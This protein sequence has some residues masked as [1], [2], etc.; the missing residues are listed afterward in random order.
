MYIILAY[1]IYSL[2]VDVDAFCSNSTNAAAI[3]E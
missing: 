1:K 2:F 3:N